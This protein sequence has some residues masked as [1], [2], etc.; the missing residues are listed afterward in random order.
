[1]DKSYT[2]GQMIH[3]MDKPNTN[4]LINITKLTNNLCF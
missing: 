3:K 2:N 4:G 1:M